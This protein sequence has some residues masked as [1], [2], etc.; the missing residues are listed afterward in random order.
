[1]EQILQDTRG[2]LKKFPEADFI[3]WP[4]G[5][6]PYPIDKAKAAAGKDPIQK[7]AA[8]FSIPLLASAEGRAGPAGASS[9]SVFAFDSKGRLIQGAYD[10]TLLLPF[11]EYAP[12]GRRLPFLNRLFLGSRPFAAGS[13]AN[14]AIR[15]GGLSMG[16]QICYEGLFR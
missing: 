7:W 8:E 2:A 14:S 3:L 9:N 16:I 10:K 12:G 4:E 11:A 13:G 6:Y 5:G 15:L 1:M